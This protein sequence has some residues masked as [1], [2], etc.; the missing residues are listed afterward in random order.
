[1]RKV[2]QSCQHLFLK[3]DIPTLKKAMC[4][5]VTNAKEENDLEEK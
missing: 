5:T 3:G 2:I 4:P 1:M